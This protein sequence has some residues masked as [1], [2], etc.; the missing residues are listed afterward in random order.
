MLMNV[1]GKTCIPVPRDV[2]YYRI[3]MTPYLA[4][5]NTKY[6]LLD[7][8]ISDAD[9]K[10]LGMTSKPR[11]MSTTNVFAV[12][13]T[14]TGSAIVKVKMVAGGEAAGSTDNIGGITITK[15]FALVV[16]EKFSDNGGWL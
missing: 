8:E 7:M 11:L 4:D 16:R 6:T 9:M 2:Q 3:D 13:C 1:A 10:R 15:E 5:G 12:T 14:K